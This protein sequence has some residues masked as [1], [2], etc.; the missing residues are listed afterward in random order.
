MRPWPFLLVFFLP[1]AAAYCAWRGDSA[2]IGVWLF[3]LALLPLADAILPPDRA[4][5]PDDAPIREAARSA[6]TWIIIAY[7]PVQI[8]VTAYVLHVGSMQALWWVDRLGIATAVGLSNGAIGFTLAHELV[9]RTGGLERAMGRVLLLGLAYPHWAVEHVRGHHRHV[10]TP[11]DAATARL[12]ESYY[13]FLP[14]TVLG[15]MGSAWRLEAERLRKIG[16]PAFSPANEILVMTA[17]ELALLVL[18][19]AWLGALGF[20]LYFLQA[21]VAV[22]LLE[23]TNYCQHYGLTRLEIAP[24]RYEPQAPRHSWNSYH[25]LTNWYTIELG[26]HSDHHAQPGRPYQ[27]LRADADAPQLPAS[28]GAMILLALIPPLWF[29]VMNPKAN[30]W[31]LAPQAALPPGATAA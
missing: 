19:V 18:V 22:I 23:G 5:A 7:V 21:I 12:N 16:R 2:W 6:F 29:R 26:R 24:G 14:R 1:L 15:Q 28:Y 11:R 27:L 10:G 25:R 20:A 17:I 31:Q 8:A 30:A 9:H 3:A 13:H 4:G